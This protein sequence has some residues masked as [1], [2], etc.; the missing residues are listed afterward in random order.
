MLMDL[1]TESLMIM[2]EDILVMRPNTCQMSSTG[3]GYGGAITKN[4]VARHTADIRFAEELTTDNGDLTNTDIFFFRS[5]D[6]QLR[7]DQAIVGYSENGQDCLMY[8][9]LGLTIQGLDYQ[10]IGGEHFLFVTG[11]VGNS[12]AFV[13]FNLNSGMSS[14]VQTFT[15]NPI[16]HLHV[17]VGLLGELQLTVMPQCYI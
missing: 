10:K 14:G 4:T 16:I 5:N 3:M 9:E 7:D 6:R 8:I 15:G 2:L 1:E 11:R 17:L 13:S 12:S